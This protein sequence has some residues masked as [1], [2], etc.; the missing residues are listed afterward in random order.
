MLGRGSV[1]PRGMYGSAAA[2]AQ[3]YPPSPLRLNSPPRRLAR[4]LRS[5]ERCARQSGRPTLPAETDST[6]LAGPPSD[7]A[8]CD[9]SGV[10]HESIILLWANVHQPAT[11]VAHPP[12]SLESC[13]RARARDRDGGSCLLR[14]QPNQ[15]A[16]SG[17]RRTLRRCC[18]GLDRASFAARLGNPT[19]ADTSEILCV[20]NS[21][22]Q[23][24]RVPLDIPHSRGP[25]VHGV[26]LWP[27]ALWRGNPLSSWLPG[28]A[29]SGTAHAVGPSVAS[30]PDRRCLRE[31]TSKHSITRRR[32][33]GAGS[34]TAGSHRENV[35]EPLA[36]CTFS[37][38]RKLPVD[39]MHK[40]L[41]IHQT[42]SPKQCR[43]DRSLAHPQGAL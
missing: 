13:S 4:R 30:E 25:Y 20:L 7:P 16:A 36:S 33:V 17:L 10:F 6:A 31:P 14:C 22:G 11:N 27:P 12:I 2:D 39:L 37:A 24:S 40:L 15:M 3:P 29:A 38:W 1:Q 28:R 43:T 23:T 21:I 34:A 26:R 42:G 32:S 35:A 5:G 8:V 18:D 41:R 19:R 9:R